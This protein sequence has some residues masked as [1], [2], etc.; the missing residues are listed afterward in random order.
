MELTVKIDTEALRPSQE[1]EQGSRPVGRHASHAGR[2]AANRVELPS[3]IVGLAVGLVIA[4]LRFAEC[5]VIKI[6][7][8]N[9]QGRR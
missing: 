5:E 6:R 4:L 9:S 3:L 8:D 1:E 7:T 2:S